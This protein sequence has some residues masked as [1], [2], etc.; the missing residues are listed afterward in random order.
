MTLVSD[1]VI[2][3]DREVAQ[4]F[5]VSIDPMSI[6]E[7][8]ANGTITRNL[9]G[10]PNGHTGTVTYSWAKLEPQSPN[11]TIM[12][13]NSQNTPIEISGANQEVSQV[14]ELT[15]NDDGTGLEAKATAM[16]FISFGTV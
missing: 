3:R 7:F 11:V 5:T 10:I 14:I 8:V 2:F 15:A 16:I 4:A 9:T 1:I 6:V 13:A 12:A